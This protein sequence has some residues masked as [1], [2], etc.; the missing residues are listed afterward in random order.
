MNLI[1]VYLGNSMIVQ[2]GYQVLKSMGLE[3]IVVQ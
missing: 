1:Y 2:E 3:P